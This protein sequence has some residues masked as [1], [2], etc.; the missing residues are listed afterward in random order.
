MKKV[1]NNK[2]K[3]LIGQAASGFTDNP[4]RGKYNNDKLYNF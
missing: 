2:K 3:I 4:S 1:N